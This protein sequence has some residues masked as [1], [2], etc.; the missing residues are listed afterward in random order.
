MKRKLCL[1]TTG[2]DTTQG[3]YK[4]AIANKNFDQWMTQ[5]SVKYAKK[6]KDLYYSHST[7]KHN[8]DD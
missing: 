1:N 8:W 2:N 5:N 7:M 3:V 6:A 4:D